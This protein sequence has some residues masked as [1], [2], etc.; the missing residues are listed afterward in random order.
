MEQHNDFSYLNEA[1][2][3]EIAKYLDN[4]V[5]SG[6]VKKVILSGVYF[7]GVMEAGKPHDALKNFILGTMAQPNTMNSTDDVIG[8]QLRGIIH[9]VSLVESGFRH[10]EKLRKVEVI[11]NNPINRGK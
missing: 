4:S 2:K 7:D 5:L 9:G 10:L 1:E 8:A 6:A 3:N 11:K